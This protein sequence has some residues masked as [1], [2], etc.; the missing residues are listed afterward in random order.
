MFALLR[1]NAARF[2][3]WEGAIF[4]LGAT[5]LGVGNY[6]CLR[7]GDAAY[8]FFHLLGGAPSAQRQNKKNIFKITH[9]ST[10][11]SLT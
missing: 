10:L 4:F 3:A 5:F 9:F 6:R 11:Q 8:Q 1:N 2:S 7:R